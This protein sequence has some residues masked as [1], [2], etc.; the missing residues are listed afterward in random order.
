LGDRYSDV[1][2]PGMMSIDEVEENVALAGGSY[3]LT[4]AEWKLIGQDKRDLGTD[5]CRG[6]DYCQP[7][8][9]GIPI[10]FVLRAE[11]GFMKR[12]GWP[13]R[14]DKQFREAIPKVES[15]IHCGEC[16]SRC[17]YHLDIPELLPA[18]VASL[19]ARVER[20]DY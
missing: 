11:K 14:L 19:L 8:P 20:G 16:A 5:Y 9:Q 2:I 7:C 17:P 15:C 10:S 3:E 12:M 6:C 4:P 1:V 13:E 18:K